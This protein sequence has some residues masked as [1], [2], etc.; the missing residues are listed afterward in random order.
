MNSDPTEPIGSTPAAPVASAPAV[1][2][3]QGLSE[4]EMN[5]LLARV[6]VILCRPSHPGNIGAAA[7]ALKTMGLAD[8]ALVTPLR[9]VD[10]EAVAR[11]S[12]AAEVLEQAPRHDSLAAALADTVFAVALSARAREVGPPPRAP[13]EAV[14]ELLA[15]ARHG[16]VAL[17][18]GNET[19]G[20]TNEEVLCCQREVTIPANPAYSSLNLGAAVQVLAYEVRQA[21]LADLDPATR[22]PA[23]PRAVTRFASAPASHADVEGL[24]AHFER[25]MV[26]TGFLN[27]ER[28][29]RL[30]A[31]LRRL[32][33][34]SG[35]ERDE[36]NILRGVLAATESPQPGA[37]PGGL[38]T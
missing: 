2:P 23:G 28:P 36:V 18:F 34:R 29:R 14:A 13:R 15:Y 3:A 32:F 38:D 19:T 17:V 1:H 37:E 8:L 20:L 21:L 22:L 33:E 35:L 11:A 9:P 10:E 26:A 6:R 5:E 7:R 16:K 30:M 27:P 4:S 12:G 31:K 24:L 25:V